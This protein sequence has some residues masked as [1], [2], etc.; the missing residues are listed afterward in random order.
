MMAVYQKKEYSAAGAVLYRGT[1]TK[2]NPVGNR[3][4]HTWQRLK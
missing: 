4:K 2:N 3:R 1:Q